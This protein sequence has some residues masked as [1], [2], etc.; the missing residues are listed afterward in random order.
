V[1]DFRE[2]WARAAKELRRAVQNLHLAIPL[3]G[4]EIRRLEDVRKTVIG[5][6]KPIAEITQ[7]ITRN[8]A[9]SRE[10]QRE[11]E[12]LDGSER[13]LEMRRTVKILEYDSEE[14]DRPRT[15]CMQCAK[16]AQ[17]EDINCAEYAA[18]CHEGGYLD[19]VV[20]MALGDP[21]LTSCSSTSG[22]VCTPTTR[23][24]PERSSSTIPE[25]RRGSETLGI[26]RARLS[27]LSQ[28]TEMGEQYEAEQRRIIEIGAR[29]ALFVEKNAILGFNA[30]LGAYLKA[31]IESL[32]NRIP[33][34]LSEPHEHILQSL[35]NFRR[36][37]DSCNEERRT[38]QEAVSNGDAAVPTA[39]E[40]EAM[41]HELEG[42]PLVGRG[43]QQA[44][45]DICHHANCAGGPRDV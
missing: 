8:I 15:V 3:H 36:S 25:P 33:S 29:F 5:L 44:L 28:S 43:F 19:N 24:A 10:H 35:E 31:Q 32:Q 42:L 27:R 18:A 9:I 23:R 11:L 13:G 6:S 4:G 38:F 21:N 45:R 14:F 2:S 39:G 30:S 7:I 20:P 41:I 1:D 22:S 40:V 26:E 17:I 12:S 34:D 16:Y 37:L